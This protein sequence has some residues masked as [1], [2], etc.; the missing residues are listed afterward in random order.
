MTSSG[1]SP[2]RIAV[3]DVLE[4]VVFQDNADALQH[5]DI[6]V[7]FLEDAVHVHA[8]CGDASGEVNHCH[9]AVQDVLMY[10]SSNVDHCFFSFVLV[11]GRPVRDTRA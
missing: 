7:V 10:F 2:E 8:G 9:P 3:G 1:H 6:N 5:F 11:P 4:E